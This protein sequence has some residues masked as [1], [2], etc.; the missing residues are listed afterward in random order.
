MN[1]KES[2]IRLLSEIIKNIDNLP[3]GSFWIRD[4]KEEKFRFP[5]WLSVGNGEQIHITPEIDGMLVRFSKLLMM[6]Y[7]QPRQSDFTHAEWNSLVKRVFGKCFRKFFL[8]ECTRRD[9]EAFLEELK[10]AISD[11]I[12]DI[13]EREYVFG[14]HFCSI[15]EFEPL[16]IGPVRFEPKLTWLTRIHQS[17]GIS[18]ISRV[19]IEKAWQ[20]KKL[21]RRKQSWDEVN[22][23][24][25]LASTEG[26][27]FVCSVAVGPMGDNAGKQKALVAA[28]L[29]TTAVALAWKRA[30]WALSYINL[31]YDRQPYHRENLVTSSGKSFGW[32]SSLSYIPGGIKSLNAAQWDTLRTDFGEL[33]ACA[34]QAIRYLTHGKAAVSK[35][36]LMEALFQSLLWFYEGC[37]DDVDSMA[38]VKF[39]SAMEALACGRNVRG[40]LNLAKARLRIRD[41]DQ[42]GKDLRSLYQEGRSRTVH[43]TNDRLGRDWSDSRDHAEQLAQACLISCLQCVAENK[44]RDDPRLFS[45]RIG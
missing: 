32:H 17:G 40:I 33:H 26:C 9:T 3:S 7:F 23:R 22:E 38:I 35:P 39:C 45:Q 13:R 27:D 41:E 43:G 42:F 19:R 25:I 12:R 6:V 37:R 36:K 44:V 20:G 31:T 2:C 14:C 21:R 11:L 28:R 30:T 18:K 34:G 1:N 24:Q 15:S 4:L 29:A 8:E 10:Q 16:S 5:V